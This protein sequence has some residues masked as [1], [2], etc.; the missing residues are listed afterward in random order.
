MCKGKNHSKTVDQWISGSVPTGKVNEDGPLR[1][2][3]GT[4]QEKA[5][6]IANELDCSRST[7]L[8]YVPPCVSRGCK[9]DNLCGYCECLAQLRREAVGFANDLGGSF[10]HKERKN[11]LLTYIVY[12]A[13]REV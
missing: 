6:D 12:A 2:V 10:D 11:L 3:R 7:A 8:K 4:L 1:Q 13:T 5:D 9:M